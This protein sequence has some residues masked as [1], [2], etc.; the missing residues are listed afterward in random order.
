MK[1]KFEIVSR[2]FYIFSKKS[3]EY[4]MLKGRLFVVDDNTLKVTIDTKIVSVRTPKP[5]KEQ[6][7]K[8]IGDIMAD[9]LQLEKGDYIF[10]WCTKSANQKSR[11]YGVYRVISAPYYHMDSSTDEYPF[12]IRVEQAYIFDHPLEEYDLLNSAH[13]KIPLWTVIGKK[14]ADKKR[15]STPLTFDEIQCIITMLI[16]R[17]HNYTFIP[18]DDSRFDTTVD[19]LKIDYRLK[20]N[21]PERTTLELLNPNKMY[22]LNSDGSLKYEKFLETIFNQEMSL[23][24]KKFF[25][26]LGLDVDHIV[27]YS[28]YLPY[29]IEQSEMDYLLMESI[30]GQ[31]INK[32]Y[33]VEFMKTI[34]DDDHIERCLQYS[35]WVSDTLSLGTLTVQ[36]ILICANY[37]KRSSDKLEELI[38]QLEESYKTMRLQVYCYDFSG[39]NPS[40][41]KA[42]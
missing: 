5:E 2:T 11:I 8:T 29:S 36:P 4:S 39:D 34:I 15:A 32:M 13:I 16:D 27:W 23:K 35:K 19:G 42:R 25:E 7:E 40:F 10:L 6:W 30:D 33:L 28:N 22:F 24:N 26:Q 17:N 37:R 38:M 20:G 18:R 14:V 31:I 12:K 41:Y 1:R 3:K 9:M 21:N